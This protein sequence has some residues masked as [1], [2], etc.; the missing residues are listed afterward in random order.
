MTVA[1]PP[2]TWPL[3]FWPDDPAPGDPLWPNERHPWSR[4]MVE[5]G[6]EQ[7]SQPGD[8]VLDPFASQPALARAA[9]ASRRRLVLNNAS[10]AALLA[11]LAGAAP[12]A[13]AV[14][15]HAFS[16]IADAPR[17]GR[18]LAHHLAALYET[19]CPECAQ[20]MA[21]DCFVWD[22]QIGEPVE[23]QYRCPH[24]GSQGDAPADMVDVAQVSS[25]EVRGAAYWGLLSR[26]VKPGDPLTAEARSL[27]DLY[28]AR[29]LLVLSEL[30]TAAEQR[31]ADSEELRAGRAMILHV[32]A[33]GLG[34]N[35]MRAGREPGRIQLPRRF[36]EHNLWLAFEHAHRTLR[37]RPQGDPARRDRALPLASD[38]TR[39][40]AP[41]GE[42]RV[43][44]TTLSTPELA[45][46]IAPGSVAL[47]L[48]EPP[49]FDPASY[50]L[51]FLWS[52]WLYGREA[53]NRQRAALSIEQWSWDW[54]TRAVSAALRTL[55]PLLQPEGRMVLAFG[56]ESARRGMAVLAAAGAAG[57]RLAA[58]ASAASLYPPTGRTCWRFELAPAEQPLSGSAASL[59]DRA[60]HS[61][62]EAAR[63]LLDARGE[64][65]PPALV[66]TA[67]AVR[68][69]ELGVL[70]ELARHP[71][72]ARQPI[73][74]LLAQLRLALA[75]DLPPPGLV[76]VAADPDQG[77]LW[78]AE[79]LSTQAPLADRVEQFVAGQLEAGPA[80]PQALT[81]A[82]FAAFPGWLTPDAALLAACLESYGQPD[83]E[84][85]RLRPED[86]PMRR[87]EDLAGMVRL[88]VDLG[89]RLGYEVW[90]APQKAPLLAADRLGDEQAAARPADWAPAS[91]VWHAA[92]DPAFAFAVVAQAGLHAWLAAPSEALAG[93]PRYVALPGGRA[94]LLDFKLR[95]CPPWRTRL[96]WAGWEFVKFRHLRD[97]AGQPGLSL[98]GFR[99][100]IGLDPIVT[101]PGQQLAL[102]EMENEGDADDA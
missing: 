41:D 62:Q 11:A 36:V 29:A 77:G 67:C 33:A 79:Q 86:A 76:F 39:L 90:L 38:L 91:V 84:L 20:S 88:L 71:E 56:D 94:G 19:I 89:R 78:L 30:L 9:S 70:A 5:R 40:R 66:Q 61:A 65:A 37:A 59:A 24:C 16:R 31:L 69:S 35:G 17:R 64:P 6:L 101:L 51:Q 4:E 47:I 50:A 13:P 95:R 25:L 53:A 26:L 72:A 3:P 81:E 7:Y 60:Q 45:E 18:T 75:R 99:A 10:P 52:G 100:R 68:W 93:C 44:P 55:R 96:A 54:Y 82:T 57:W 21:A 48:T 43:L 23:K 42:G 49:A 58:Q 80:A 32:M 83:G 102:F 87:S 1:D 15:D 98:A 97:L 34:G 2:I 92:G 85:L 14:V 46:H 27:Q 28:P 12:P 73:S 63:Q 22:R 74:F 8:L